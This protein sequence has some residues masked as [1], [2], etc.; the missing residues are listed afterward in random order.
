MEK[1]GGT[2][3]V[4]ESAPTSPAINVI[5]RYVR[6]SKGRVDPADLMID[7]ATFS[8]LVDFQCSKL[9]GD[10]RKIRFVVAVTLKTLNEDLSSRA[11]RGRRRRRRRVQ[12]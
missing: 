1:D 8:V 9:R 10:R 5:S 2:A 3:S 6:R 7:R 12:T 4:I 11:S